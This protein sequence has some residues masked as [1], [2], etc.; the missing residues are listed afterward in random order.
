MLVLVMSESEFIM[1]GD[2]IQGEG[3]PVGASISIIMGL[4][5]ISPEFHKD[6]KERTCKLVRLLEC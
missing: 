2:E 6:Y 1:L 4:R 3:R 5:Y